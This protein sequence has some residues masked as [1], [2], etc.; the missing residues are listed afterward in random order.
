MVAANWDFLSLSMRL[1][2]E[3]RRRFEIQTSFR[4]LYFFFLSFYPGTT[5]ILPP[6]VH[7]CN[8]S[9]IRL[10]T[11]LFHTRQ[12]IMEKGTRC[13]NRCRVI[14][15]QSGKPRT[16]WEQ[17]FF[18]R[19]PTLNYWGTA[20]ARKTPFYLRGGRVGWSGWVAARWVNWKVGWI[21]DG[22]GQQT[23]WKRW[24]ELKVEGKRDG[25][26]LLLLF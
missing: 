17:S 8:N 4:H 18:L 7:Q 16:P 2:N 15:H 3:K 20:N 10:T 13:K 21:D 1:F 11:Y 24:K 23:C 19:H 26:P 14:F 22:A 12:F 6:S 25:S 5:L 9:S